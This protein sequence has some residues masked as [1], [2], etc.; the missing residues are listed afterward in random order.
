LPISDRIIFALDDVLADPKKR[1]CHIEKAKPDW[2]AYYRQDLV[3]EDAHV[4]AMVALC[5]QLAENNEI[6]L[7][8]DRPMTVSEVTRR[9]LHG[10]GIP[11]DMI[12]WRQS[13]APSD[14]IEHKL[15]VARN[16]G[17]EGLRPWLAIDCDPIVIGEYRRVGVKALLSSAN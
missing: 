11:F 8:T 16:L 7:V 15:K 5:K 17:A 6:V 12:L 1:R 13:L 14:G 3:E 4:P 10:H 2:R 9:W